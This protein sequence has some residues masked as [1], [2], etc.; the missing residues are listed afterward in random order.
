M[1]LLNVFVRKFLITGLEQFF[2]SWC[3]LFGWLW[4]ILFIDSL[5]FY[6]SEHFVN[7]SLRYDRDINTKRLSIQ[8]HEWS[9]R[10][11]FFSL[12]LGFGS[13]SIQQ[14]WGRHLTIIILYS[15]L[16]TFELI[17]KLI[18]FIW[19]ANRSFFIWNFSAI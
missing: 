5:F 6:L 12:I 4:L 2:F 3:G 11:I 10:K 19:L 16:V 1:I 15:F 7:I 13:F 18:I 17:F 8:V 9:I 14:F